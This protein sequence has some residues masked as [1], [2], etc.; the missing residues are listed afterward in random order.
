MPTATYLEGDRVR[1][2][3]R[4]SRGTTNYIYSNVATW[5]WKVEAHLCSNPSGLQSFNTVAWGRVYNG[6]NYLNIGGVTSPSQNY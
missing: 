1:S 6:A 5:G 2:A 4:R 3:S